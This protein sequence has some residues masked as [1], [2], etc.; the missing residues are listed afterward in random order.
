MLTE[1]LEPFLSHGL[2]SGDRE[3]NLPYLREPNAAIVYD[4]RWGVDLFGQGV[5][6]ELCCTN[7]KNLLFS[8]P[9]MLAHHTIN[10]CAMNSGDLL[11]SG[12]ISRT[13][14]GSPDSLLE[15]SENGRKMVHFGNLVRTFLEE[16]RQNRDPR[17]MRRAWNL[18]WFW[19]MR[20]TCFTCLHLTIELLQWWM[21]DSIMSKFMRQR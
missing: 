11:G 14:P 19:G 17:C 8:L 21:T 13:E 3:I 6:S 18:R 12:T 2:E 15:Q 9:Q 20:R 4:I 16:R 7:G 5:S 1:A 10:G